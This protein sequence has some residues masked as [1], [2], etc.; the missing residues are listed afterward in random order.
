MTGRLELE[1]LAYTRCG[2]FRMIAS[3]PT[4]SVTLAMA[5]LVMGCPH[6]SS[7]ALDQATLNQITDTAKIICTEPP[8]TENHN[9]AELTGRAHAELKSGIARIV[10]LGAD[11]SGNLRKGSSTGVLQD[12]LAL[13]IKQSNDCKLA[14][15][16][17]L[18]AFLKPVHVVRPAH[19]TTTRTVPH[20]PTTVKI[21]F[22]TPGNMP[23]GGLAADTYLAKQGVVITKYPRKSSVLFTNSEQLYND[24][25]I[26]E[27]GNILTQQLSGDNDIGTLSFTLTFDSP[28]ESVSFTRAKLWADTSSGVTHPAWTAYALDGSGNVISSQS[29]ELT[30]SFGVV[31]AR[32]FTLEATSTRHIAALRFESDWRLNG[33]PFA[34]FRA[35]LIK[36]LTLTR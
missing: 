28:V 26:Q 27:E 4:F 36:S 33:R 8:I 11:V 14:V 32:G 12:Q 24:R 31:P 6:A 2:R 29:E 34:G 5:W 21:D 7:Q 16:N 15:F 18:H 9:S 3:R 20:P 1:D 22:S 35:V 10:G 17:T 23:A 19:P 30:R 25:A 13:A